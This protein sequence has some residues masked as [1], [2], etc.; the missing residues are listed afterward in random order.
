MASDRNEDAETRRILDRVN[1]E[2][3]G[4][5]LSGAMDEARGFV[6][7]KDGE[8]EDRVEYWGTRIGRSISLI[9]TVAVIGGCLIYLFTR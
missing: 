5:I 7:K 8:A 1:R 3:Q 9:I 4:G 6:T 2:T